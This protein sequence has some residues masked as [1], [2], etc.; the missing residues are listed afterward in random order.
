VLYRRHD[1]NY[2]VIEPVTGSGSTSGRSSRAGRPTGTQ[3]PSS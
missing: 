3:S 1:G 2:G